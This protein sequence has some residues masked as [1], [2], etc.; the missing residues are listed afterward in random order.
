[1]RYGRKA[2]GARSASNTEALDVESAQHKWARSIAADIRSMGNMGIQL[3]PQAYTGNTEI[4]QMAQAIIDSREADVYETLPVS[5]T[6][7][8]F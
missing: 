1:M 2:F 7:D 4:Q 8:L 5:G 6:T 3:S